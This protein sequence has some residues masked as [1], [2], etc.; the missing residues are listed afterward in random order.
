[1]KMRTMYRACFEEAE[2]D[3]E[4]SYPADIV[5]NIGI[6]P[7][8]V[9]GGLRGMGNM[10]DKSNLLIGLG[11]VDEIRVN[12]VTYYRAFWTIDDFDIFRAS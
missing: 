3:H 7:T 1:M 11:L 6:E 9:I 8:N 5:K 10:F 12:K 4:A 2:W